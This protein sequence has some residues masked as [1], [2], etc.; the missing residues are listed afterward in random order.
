MRCCMI[1]DRT[2]TSV[3]IAHYVRSCG[4]AVV[5]DPSPGDQC[6]AVSARTTA[7]EIL[8]CMTTELCSVPPET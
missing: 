7:C 2:I 8:S 1:R 3:R 6:G 5:V 4:L